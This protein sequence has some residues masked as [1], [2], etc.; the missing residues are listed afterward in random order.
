MGQARGGAGYDRAKAIA[1]NGTGIYLTGECAKAASFDGLS[2]SDG[3][4]FVAKLTDAG[5]TA[6]FDWVQ[7]ADGTLLALAATSSAV[8]TAGYF[9]GTAS[10]GGTSLTS[11]GAT[12]VVVAKLVDA[13]STGAFAWAQRAGG[14][15]S[16]YLTGLSASGASVYLTGQYSSAQA[17]FGGTTLARTS[18]ATANSFVAK[19]MD[20]GSTGNFIWALSSAGETAAN[21]VA[22]APGAVYVAGSFQGVA[23]FGSTTLNSG[24]GGSIF[25]AKLTDAGSTAAF[26]WT[27]QAGGST[28]DDAQ[29]LAVVG[30]I[31]Y[32]GGRLARAGSF[33]PFTVPAATD[34][35]L[36][37][38]RL[39]DI[40]QTA[41][42]NWVQTGSS[43]DYGQAMCLAAVGPRVYLSGR[44]SAPAVF[45]S[46]SL[47]LPGGPAAFL[48]TLTIPVL[49]A[50]PASSLAG[51]TV[52]PNP[53]HGTTT[54]Q[55]PLGAGA[56][57]TALV[58]HDALGRVARRY[59]APAGPSYLLDL[60]GLAPGVYAL[61]IET[62]GA[63]A[64][65]RLVVE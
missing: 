33:G 21:A 17:A 65:R 59:A 39:T 30:S 8:Y 43:G 36:Y 48:A 44:A 24:T 53:A 6:S 58:L 50:A 12:D 42:F 32:V 61:R 40:G 7:R 37:L 26:T 56:A 28:L 18:S 1:L 46:F 15:N 19:L 25:V 9:T 20:A 62:A 10:F 45:G 60:A 23:G 54:V 47:S 3:P 22:S 27:Q 63:P 31:V 4:S 49:A 5:S 11:A 13:G 38:T 16:E 64:T 34:R 29:G 55:V 51:L 2:L 57:P 52:A 41:N 35:N 14:D